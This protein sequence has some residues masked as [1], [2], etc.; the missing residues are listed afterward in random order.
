MA[1]VVE[2]LTRTEELAQHELKN[3]AFQAVLTLVTNN[4]LLK[5]AF[6]LKLLHLM[7]FLSEK[8]RPRYSSTRVELIF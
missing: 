6:G 5:T 2:C 7:A 4:T 3:Q 8:S 1:S